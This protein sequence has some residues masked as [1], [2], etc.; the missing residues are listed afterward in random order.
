MN[1][2]I[3]WFA[4][5][6]VAA[7]ILMVSIIASGAYSMMNNT[8]IQEFPDYK[9]R[10]ITVSV[11][12]RGSTPTEIEE[13]IVLRLEENLFDVE[14][15]TEMDARASAS[16]GSVSLTIDD[17][18]D[19]N[20][21]LDE[22]KNRVDTIRTFPIEA[23]RP[24]I[25]FRSFEERV[26]TVV[27]AGD[28]SETEL[29]VLGES[30][31]DEIGAL[32][33]VTLTSL[34]A[35]RPYEIAIEVPE[36][37][38]KQYG[39]SF[40]TVVRAVRNHS[41]DLSA[42]SIKT[43]GGNIL[44]RTSQQAYTQQEFDRIPVL[45][46]EDGTRITLADI[47][48]VQDGFDEMP[49]EARFNGKRAIAIDVVRTGDQSL[50]E[51][52][53]DVKE[54]IDIKS[55]TLPDGIELT[56]WQDDSAR[57][58]A[59]LSA[60][61]GSSIIAF[62]LVMIILSLFLRPT[63]AFWVALGIPIAFAGAFFILPLIDV[64][65]NRITLFA[66]ILVLG[67][68]VDDAIVTGEN[69]Y[70]H[71]RRG[72]GPLE[73]AIKGTQE[74]AT[75]VIFGVI[76]TM[77]AFY[78]IATMTGGRGS[79]FKMIPLVVIPV[80]CFSLIESK[81]ILPAHL[82]HCKNLGKNESSKN[83]LMRFQRFF[84]D[85]LEKFVLVYYKP[86]LEFCL[87]FRYGTAAFF[88][89][90]LLVFIGVIVGDRLPYSSFPRIPRDRVQV[91]L[92]MPSGTTFEVTQKH[93][94]NVEMHALA[95][96]KEL[97]EKHGVEIITD[98]FATSG[99]RPFGGGGPGRGRGPTAGVAEQG[100]VVIEMLSAEESGVEI[101][102]RDVTLALRDLV[103]P[104]PEA[105]QFS[106]SFSR[107]SDGALEVQLVSPNIDDL[108]E[109]SLVLQKKMASYE[110]LYD[111]EDSF[112]NATEELELE[113]KPAASHLGV[114]AQQLASQVRQAFFGS[115]AQKIQRGRD[116]VNVMVRYPK[117]ERRS[118]ASLRTM[119]IRTQNGTEVPF[120]EVA[121]VVPGKA[122]PSIRRVNRNR[123]IRVS[124]DGDSE[125]VD[126]DAIQA[127]II[128]N[129]LPP[130]VAKYSGMS[131]SLEGRERST[132]DNNAELIKGVYFVLVFI[133]VLLAIPFK[134]Y[135]QPLIV[136]SAIPFGI[137]GALLGHMVMNF[138]LLNIL[139]RAASPASNVSMMSLLGMMA[140]SGVVVNDSLVM[141]DF[142][143]RQMKKGLKIGEAVRLAGVR[144]FRAILLTSLT[145][146]FGLA[147]L[148]FDAG[149]Q[150]QWLIPMAISL[151]WGII[152]A[153]AITLVLVPVITLIFEDIRV[154]FCKLY[155]RPIERVD[156][157][158][159]EKKLFPAEVG[160]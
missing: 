72:T 7:N 154:L 119:M 147:P 4:R 149:S 103:G 143:N 160:S 89:G 101:G 157:D 78:P 118:L 87:K 28:L 142:I 158:E 51:I 145:T 150:T 99:G 6:G 152:F 90:L 123:I 132:R 79:F 10:T 159:E 111:I 108:K 126:V 30:I 127:D 26:I 76:T 19:I 43:E 73:S 121:E 98:I 48:H 92:T 20:R 120:E 155:N 44:L 136:M 75:P 86:V 144:R 57:V 113:L 97:N 71:M 85:G 9:S 33:S 1:R 67:I 156:H 32:G 45:T 133:Y 83:W 81:L 35:V 53:N 24:Q 117:E 2:I 153:T 54:Y 27:L 36:T 129:F 102:S 42:G 94:N 95:Y 69:I 115:E 107:G 64:S 130:L 140:L 91:G 96:R 131:V 47:A 49:I 11:T 60:L 63:L 84:A 41:V 8:V 122:L 137:I 134:S 135:A 109:V 18:Y 114:T 29:K 77:V 14:G 110:G 100:E 40:D 22:I 12:Y 66:F 125:T 74:I 21:A 3:E 46:T 128:D 112:E 88:V 65:V 52:G 5:N 146:F 56:Y 106:F 138:I 16:S 58:G 34:K 105:E 139:G 38:L 59:M 39:L 70:Q 25:T 17:N 148:M 151:G 62:F 31:R 37:I 50:M 55:E 124:A 116:D 15:V 141:V 13:S 104:I 23:E 68:V 93:I 82:K 80:L 61:K